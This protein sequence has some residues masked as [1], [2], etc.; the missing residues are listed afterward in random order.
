M[1]LENEGS[2]MVMPV[3]PMYGSGNGGFGFGNDGGWW[4][5]ILFL[6]LGGLSVLLTA[7][8]VSL[9][10]ISSLLE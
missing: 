8:A 9:A 3:S 7:S 5:L 2:N 6:L 10:Y 4:I 1:A